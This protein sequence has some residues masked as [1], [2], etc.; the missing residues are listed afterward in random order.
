MEMMLKRKQGLAAVIFFTVLMLLIGTSSYSADVQVANADSSPAKP[1]LSLP[2]GNNDPQDDAISS[3]KMTLPPVPYKNEG[4]AVLF[5]TYIGMMAGG[6]VGLPLGMVIVVPAGIL[7]YGVFPI[8][9]FETGQDPEK[10]NPVPVGTELAV[11]GSK[12]VVWLSYGVGYIVGFPFLAVKKIVY[13]LPKSLFYDPFHKEEKAG[14][15][16]K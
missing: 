13:D 9:L 2:E 1:E 3:I 6:L 14:Q 15:A 11:M 10:D 5:P 8:I 12:P 7:G 16:V 4:F